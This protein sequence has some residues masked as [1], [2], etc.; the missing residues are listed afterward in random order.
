MN[1]LAQYSKPSGA[2]QLYAQPASFVQYTRYALFLDVRCSCFIAVW[3]VRFATVCTGTTF[4]GFHC[5]GLHN[6]A[7][8]LQACDMLCPL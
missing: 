5:K 1:E 3:F 6:D 4:Q 2:L 8:P 7:L